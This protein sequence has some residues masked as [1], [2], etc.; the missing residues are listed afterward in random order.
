[1]VTLP[2]TKATRGRE[3]KNSRSRQTREMR[4]LSQ[5][6]ERQLALERLL[7]L[8]AV[9]AEQNPA[10]AGRD[11]ANALSRMA[12]LRAA[13]ASYALATTGEMERVGVGAWMRR[14]EAVKPNN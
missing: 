1:M 3:R 14:R 2:S 13:H 4:Q 11:R 7:N 6:V 10:R 12:R 8:L 9:E 5:E